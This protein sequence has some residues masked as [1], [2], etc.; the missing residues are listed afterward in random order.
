MFRSSAA[1]QESPRGGAGRPGRRACR[2]RRGP[3]DPDRRGAMSEDERYREFLRAHDR[4][5]ERHGYMCQAVM[6]DLETE[7]CE[8]AGPLALVAAYQRLLDADPEVAEFQARFPDTDS[9]WR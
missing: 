8:A 7:G 6:D 2:L 5:F 9:V 1:M 3:S 4:L